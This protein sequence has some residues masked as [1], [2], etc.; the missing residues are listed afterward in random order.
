VKVVAR[1][2]LAAMAWAQVVGRATTMAMTGAVVTQRAHAM[3]AAPGKAAAFVALAVVH[4][5]AALE[6]V[7]AAT[8]VVMPA[9]T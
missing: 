3:T 6:R 2:S 7:A 4:A 8:A 5:A 9:K 1:G